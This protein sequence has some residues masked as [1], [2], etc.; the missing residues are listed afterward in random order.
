MITGNADYDMDCKSEMLK[1]NL[2][3]SY[4][5]VVVKSMEFKKVQH[6]F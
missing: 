1:S 6:L 2:S 4:T 3:F 5:V